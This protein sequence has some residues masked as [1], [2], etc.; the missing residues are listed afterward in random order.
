MK[1]EGNPRWFKSALVVENLD[2][3]KIKKVVIKTFIER[4]KISLLKD[5][6]R[7]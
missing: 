7:K 5:D 1:C 6:I 2:R 4:I 3:K